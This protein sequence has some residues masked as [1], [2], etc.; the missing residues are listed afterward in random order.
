MM[1][2][3]DRLKKYQKEFDYLS[4]GVEDEILLDN[5]QLDKVLIKQIDL[6]V[7]W[8]RLYAKVYSLHKECKLDSE[9]AFGQAYTD[10]VSDAY[11]S[12]SSTDAKHKALC[13]DS[14]IKTKQLENK[15]LRLE[16]EVEGFV[17][18][19]ES[20]KY[21]LKDLAATIIKECNKQIL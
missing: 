6:Q 2:I 16:K 13:N 18:V 8:N 15:V 4:K 14:Y 20:R 10:A 11:K 17:D 21:I 19:I 12:V 1:T 3:N 5:K 7:K 9:A